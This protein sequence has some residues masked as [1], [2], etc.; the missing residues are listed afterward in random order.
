M[1]TENKVI[2]TVEGTGAAINISCGFIPRYVKCWNIDA[3]IPCELEWIYGMGAAAGWKKRDGVDTLYTLAI[4]NG[5]VEIVPGDIVLEGAASGGA[6]TGASA[7]VVHVPAASSG[8]WAGGD[9]L[10][11]LIVKDVVGTWTE[12]EQV[13][14]GTTQCALAAATPTALYAGATGVF[15][16]RSTD[17]LASLGISEYVGSASAAKGFTIGADTNLN[18]SGETILYMALR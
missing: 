10:G 6:L 16:N 1:D 3:K 5:S 4:D 18:V 7:V 13:I 14:V 12:N 17:V 2:S 9:W 15:P 8:T 11:S